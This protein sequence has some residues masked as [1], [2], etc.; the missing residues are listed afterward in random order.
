MIFLYMLKET[1]VC[2]LCEVT[3]TDNDH[4]SLI[5]KWEKHMEKHKDETQKLENIFKQ[6]VM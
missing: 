5:K 6:Y 4:H 3:F 1:M 2:P